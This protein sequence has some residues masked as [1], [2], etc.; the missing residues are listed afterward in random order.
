MLAL[1]NG[2]G[3]TAID[4]QLEE[5]RQRMQ[6]NEQRRALMEARA[7]QLEAQKAVL[8][9]EVE[10][11]TRTIRTILDNVTFGFFLL[12][13]QGVVMPGA[14]ASCASLFG[15]D[16]SGRA[17]ADVLRQPQR[18]GDISA[19]LGQVFDDF[20]PEEV[21]LS[22]LPTTCEIN[23]RSL[24]L[25]ARLV[26]GS[27]GTP[28]QVL[29]S[30]SDL[31][32][33]RASQREA[34]RNHT[35]VTVLSQRA[36]FTAFLEDLREQLVE[37]EAAVA[38]RDDV[39]ARRVVHTIK[40]NAACFGLSDTVHVCHRI[41]EGAVIE[42]AGVQEIRESVRSFL[43]AHVAVLGMSDEDAT[44]AQLVIDEAR[45]KRLFD[46][47]RASGSV[48]L[49]AFANR[50]RWQPAEGV[51]A[52]LVT[53]AQRL[54][55]R[56]EKDVDITLDAG[57]ALLDMDLLRPV[58]R[59]LP[60]VVRNAVDHGVEDGAVRRA[61]GK[62]PRSSVRIA[63]AENDS[64]WRLLVSDDGN[65]IRREAVLAKG[66]QLG[67]VPPGADAQDD[68]LITRLIFSDALSTA[69][70]TTEI[71]GRGVGLP[72]LRDAVS[73]CGGS[74]VVRSTPASGTSFVIDIPRHTAA[75]HAA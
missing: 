37:A 75:R 14:T 48:E 60:H 13:A 67:L 49:Q 61:V 25:E 5:A 32:A 43:A 53:A 22:L 47:I 50:L 27:D 73:A 72:A 28:A 7:A 62:P 59:A 57:G 8:E 20:L 68:A 24:G 29:V 40:G 12:D 39:T 70:E 38:R 41:E 1:Q 23:N 4:L 15:G 21:S 33:L 31:T 11:R 3:K 64:G 35:L 18:A 9:A 26:R 52:P 44:A 51:L 58:L 55:A 30:V 19:A 16:V 42:L 69:D 10:A 34:E 45:Q 54:A 2:D 17:F 63:A 6:R 71:S 46:L 36:G 66:R 56:L 74:I 65:G